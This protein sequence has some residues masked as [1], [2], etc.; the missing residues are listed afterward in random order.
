MSEA[1]EF[2]DSENKTLEDALKQIER[3][4]GLRIDAGAFVQAV[5]DYEPNID[6]SRNERDHMNTT[7]IESNACL[8]L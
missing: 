5:I 6:A 7:T 2:L 8:G 4:E 1:S 3:L